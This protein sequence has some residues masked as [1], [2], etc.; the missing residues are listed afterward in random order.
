MGNRPNII[1]IHS[2]DTGRYVEPYGYA[3]PTPSRAALLTGTYP[4]ENGMFGLAHRGWALN[5]YREHIIHLLREHGYTSA[6]AGVQHVAN[7]ND[8]EPWKQIGYDEYLGHANVAEQVASEW[9]TRRDGT[10]FFLSVGFAETHRE[11]PELTEKEA[12]SAAYVRPPSPLP[13]TPETRLDMA[14]YAKM[15]ATLDRKIGVV[16]DALEQSGQAE[17]TLVI[18]TTDHG[19]AFP[20]MKC[21]LTDH[22]TGTMLIMR[23]PGGFRDGGVVDAMTSHLDIYPTICELLH[24]EPPPRLRGASLLPLVGGRTDRLH[25]E[26]FFEVNYHASYEPMRSVRTD[27]YRYVRRFDGRLRQILPNIDNSSS[28]DYLVAK[29]FDRIRPPEEMLFDLVMDPSESNNLCADASMSGVAA[30]LS[31][32]L[33]RFMRDTDDP[34]LDGYVL[35]S[36]TAKVTWPDASSPSGP[37]F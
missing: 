21:N 37:I 24:I 30:E 10:P 29:G 1:Y 36:A 5:D 35:P 12:K 3:I 25:D 32:R 34:L 28:K 31:S 11:F 26:L 8:S 33:D 14:A 16:L 22:G 6:L 27:R 19:I 4:H 7:H 13:D 9:L 18:C 23:G 15:A 17:N 2:H 20:K